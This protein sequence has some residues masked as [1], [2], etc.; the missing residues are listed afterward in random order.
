MCSSRPPV[1][2]F[3]VGV[4][5]NPHQGGRRLEPDGL[6]KAGFELADW[7]V[8]KNDRRAL[9]DPDN[10]AQPVLNTYDIADAKPELILFGPPD[11]ADKLELIG[12]ATDRVS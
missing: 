3:N 10:T 6:V 11:Q 9:I 1:K 5:T 7:P 12:V 4:G 2:D 8:H